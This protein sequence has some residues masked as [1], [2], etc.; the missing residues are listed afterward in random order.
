ME[1]DIDIRIHAYLEGDL[2]GDELKAFEEE[3]LT[4][5]A[6]V[7]RLAMHQRLKVQLPEALAYQAQK[8]DMR[9][10]L[11]SI[12]TSTSPVKKYLWLF[13][14]LAVISVLLALINRAFDKSCQEKE[15]LIALFQNSP[16]PAFIDPTMSAENHGHS[17]WAH[18]LMLYRAE[19]FSPARDT[20]EK[21]VPSDPDFAKGQ[22]LIGKT[23]LE[24]REWPLA[25]RRLEACRALNDQETSDEAYWRLAFAYFQ[26]EKRELVHTILS[27][28]VQTKKVHYLEARRALKLLD[29]LCD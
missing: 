13:L 29:N 16:D 17:P 20:L 8:A 14:T 5:K 6:L 26:T 25:V 15:T 23:Y 3:L 9:A 11:A 19:A 10:Y 4:D 22:F 7:E 2:S 12:K 21:I 28:I 24:Q 1:S 18:G 27:D